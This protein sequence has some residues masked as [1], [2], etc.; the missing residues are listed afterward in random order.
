MKN[1]KEAS[2]NVVRTLDIVTVDMFKPNLDS[3]LGS[4]NTTIEIQLKKVYLQARPRNTSGVAP[5]I[6]YVYDQAKGE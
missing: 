1:A 5:R 2:L 6:T 4:V 3:W